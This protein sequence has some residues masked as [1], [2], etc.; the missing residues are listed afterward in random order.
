MLG[1]SFRAVVRGHPIAVAATGL[2][3]ERLG[4][5]CGNMWWDFV[6]VPVGVDE[7]PAE[8]AHGGGIFPGFSHVALIYRSFAT[9]SSVMDCAIPESILV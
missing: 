6:W 1:C 5:I 7:Q 8:R 4:M 9:D 2:R 3:N